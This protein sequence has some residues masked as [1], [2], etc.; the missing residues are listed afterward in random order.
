MT[1]KEAL[2]EY[3]DKQIEELDKERAER[4]ESYTAIGNQASV[5][6][7]VGANMLAEKEYLDK[8]AEL[9][10][11]KEDII[12]VSPAV[13]AFLAAKPDASKFDV[14]SKKVDVDNSLNPLGGKKI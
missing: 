1:H 7:Q 9:I 2:I 4:L 13:E 3:Y 11:H 8:R 14:D 5:Y 10:K 12:G 6:K